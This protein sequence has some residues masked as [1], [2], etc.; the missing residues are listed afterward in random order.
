MD[1]VFN[2][3][4]LFIVGL[5]VATAL[6]VYSITTICKVG[7]ITYFKAISQIGKP[8][9]A[10]LFKLIT[11]SLVLLA[12]SA[13]IPGTNESTANAARGG[14]LNHRTGKLDDGTDPAGWYEKD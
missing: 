13:K 11:G 14:I 7:V 5:T 3:L 9:A 8:V 1:I 6:F 12:E 4:T 10:A 2:K